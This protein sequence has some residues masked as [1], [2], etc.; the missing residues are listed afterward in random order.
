[1]GIEVLLLALLRL[2]ET[3]DLAV[4]GAGTL[5]DTLTRLAEELGLAERVTFVGQV[6]EPELVDWYRAADLF[7]LPTIAYEGFGLVTVEA[8]ACGTPVV[9]TPVGATPELLTPLDPRLVASA[10]SDEALA[11]AVG[12][13]LEITG[14]ELRERCRR[15]A[16]ERFSWDGVADAWEEAFL[17]ASRMRARRRT[18]EGV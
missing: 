12:D 11:R 4:V 14:P 7:V 9:G 17:D 13:A 3:V 10:P 18:P 15:Y 5:G 16:C 2:P 8:L 1:M 6:S